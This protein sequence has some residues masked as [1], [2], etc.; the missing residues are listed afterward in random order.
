MF[1]LVNSPYIL[2]FGFSSTGHMKISVFPVT[3]PQNSHSVS[4]PHNQR[5]A[6]SHHVQQLHY[7]TP[8]FC[9]WKITNLHYA[10]MLGVK[11]IHKILYQQL[12]IKL[13]LPLQFQQSSWYLNFHGTNFHLVKIILKML[14]TSK[15]TWNQF[16]LHVFIKF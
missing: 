3:F 16:V 7:M 5:A 2:I 6:Y 10:V 12:A 15:E 1:T 13:D 8:L 4:W 11:N 9:K 14:H